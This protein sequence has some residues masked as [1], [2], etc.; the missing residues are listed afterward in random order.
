MQNSFEVSI[1]S[2]KEEIAF[3]VIIIEVFLL[4]ALVAIL[5]IE[6]EPF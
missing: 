3:K 1:T 6:A 5:F 4:L 2:A